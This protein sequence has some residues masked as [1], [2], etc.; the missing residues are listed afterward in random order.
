MSQTVRPHRNLSLMEEVLIAD[1]QSPDA[2]EDEEEDDNDDP[3]VQDLRDVA[4]K[5][6]WDQLFKNSTDFLLFGSLI[7]NIDLEILHPPD[8]VQIFKLWQIYLDDVNPLLKVTHTPTLQARLINA[9]GNLK[10]LEPN[11]EALMFGIYCVAVMSLTEAGCVDMFGCERE[12]L[13]QRYRFGCQQALLKC[14]FLQSDNRDCLTALF[15][16]L[17]SWLLVL[18]R[19]DC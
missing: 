10:N 11:L 19:I 2:N 9:T 8:H 15:L 18:V 5:K 16:Y 3:D 4:G 1:H 12:L 13:M 7:E 6:S 17:V 14:R